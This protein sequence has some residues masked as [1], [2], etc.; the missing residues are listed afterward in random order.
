MGAPA[1]PPAD[2]PTGIGVDDERH[3]DE[4]GPGR[5]VGKVR[6]TQH[7][8][9]R[10]IGT[11]GSPDR[12]GMVPPVADGGAHRLA[13]DHGLPSPSPAS[14]GQRCIGRRRTPRGAAAAR[15][16]GRHRR[17][18]VPGRSARPRTSRGAPVNER[19]HHFARRS[20]SPSQNRRTRLAKDLVRLNAVRDSRAP[21]LSS[22]PRRHSAHHRACRCPPR[23]LHPFVERLPGTADLR[24][25]RYYRRPPRRVILLVFQ[26]HPHRAGANLRRELVRRPCSS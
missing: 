18:A 13:A 10:S 14:T 6:H 2:D 5:H 16:C 9:R 7:V 25:D 3:V 11:G 12:A 21:R 19:H 26:Q 1:G 23:F 20:S 15:S 17:S 22:A 24:R 8:R 4:P